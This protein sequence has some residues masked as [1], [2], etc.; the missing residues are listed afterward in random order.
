MSSALD[1]VKS[2]ITEA[3]SD[4]TTSGVGVTP[5]LAGVIAAVIIAVLLIGLSSWKWARKQKKKTLKDH[6]DQ[7]NI[8]TEYVE[9]NLGQDSQ[10]YQQ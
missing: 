1:D 5:L 7:M 4:E 3:N 6:E 9:T 2:A 8:I 10:D